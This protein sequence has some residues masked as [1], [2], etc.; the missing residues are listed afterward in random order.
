MM[1]QLSEPQA[2]AALLPLFATSLSGWLS[3]DRLPKWA[4]ALIALV[5]LIG[6]AFTCVLL[7][8]NFTGN[9][10]ASTLLVLGYVALL[11]SGDLSMLRGFLV[12]SSGPLSPFAPAPPPAPITPIA[13]RAS[14]FQ[15]QQN[16]PPPATGG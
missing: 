11:M 1:P 6:T 16:Q 5:A 2:I 9:A 7:S 12:V 3:Q 13:Q 8:G 14:L 10:Q 15:Q 4:N